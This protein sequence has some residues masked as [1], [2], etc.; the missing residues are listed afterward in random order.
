MVVRSAVSY[1]QHTLKASTVHMRGRQRL[2]YWLGGSYA[3]YIFIAPFFLLFA[4]FG[5]Y[6]LLYAFNLSFTY[7]HGGDS[8]HYIGLGNYAFLLTDSMFWQS[9]S[10]SAFLWVAIVPVQ[11]IF[12]VLMAALLSR[13]V[14][15]LR[16]L[17]R[18]ALLTPYVVP[19]VA[20]AEI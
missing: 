19:L 18:T 5:L 2:C 7:W 13:P 9:L 15:R 17:F 14:L 6:P 10:N 12:A 1:N 4:G 3:P 8:W 16:W 11:T 20:V